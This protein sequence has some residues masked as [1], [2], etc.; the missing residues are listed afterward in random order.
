MLPNSQV[1]CNRVEVL[2]PGVERD[3]CVACLPSEP[4]VRTNRAMEVAAAVGFSGF[5]GESRSR[6]R[7]GRDLALS[8]IHI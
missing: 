5:E 6:S 2:L 1:G 7:R 4:M 3:A 8:L